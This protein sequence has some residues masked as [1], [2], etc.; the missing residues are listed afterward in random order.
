M[1]KKNISQLRLKKTTVSKLD[2]AIKGGKDIQAVSIVPITLACPTIITCF[3]CNVYQCD[4]ANCPTLDR[5]N[6]PDSINICIA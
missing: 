6:C 1:K 5:I 3:T 4:S 2:Q